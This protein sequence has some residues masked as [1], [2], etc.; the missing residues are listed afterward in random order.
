MP[1]KLRP[2]EFSIGETRGIHAREIEKYIP[3]QNPQKLLEYFK[4]IVP[5]IH[6]EDVL[7]Q[8]YRLENNIIE[9]GWYIPVDTNTLL[10]RIDPLIRCVEKLIKKSNLSQKEYEE[11][12]LIRNEVS[13]IESYLGSLFMGITSLSYNITSEFRPD[14]NL[15]QNAKFDL[16]EELKRM[17]KERGAEL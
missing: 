4:D 14:R 12:N 10:Q 2:E 9:S 3:N 15:E 11:L 16:E 17:K 8:L 1:Y 13:Q 6:P 7:E 5:V